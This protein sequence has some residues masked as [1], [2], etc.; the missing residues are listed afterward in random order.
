MNNF[1]YSAIRSWNQYLNANLGTSVLAVSGSVGTLVLNAYP[2]QVKLSNDTVT[3][4]VYD[5]V[6]SEVGCGRM[7]SGS[8][9]RDVTFHSQVDVWSPPNPQ[10]EPRQGANRKFKDIVEESLKD[11]VRIDLLQWDGTGGTTINGGMYVRQESASWMPDDNMDGW[12][13][14]RLSYVLRAVD[15][16]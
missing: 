9:A 14:W 15:Y 16:D 5:E 2:G 11:K 10:G 6:I 7:A 12:S 13:R 4:Y 1:T 8:K 3:A